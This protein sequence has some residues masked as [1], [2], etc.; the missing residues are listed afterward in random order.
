MEG[1]YCCFNNDLGVPSGDELGSQEG[2]PVG[3]LK[4]NP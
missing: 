2:D 4:V 3:L 1:Q